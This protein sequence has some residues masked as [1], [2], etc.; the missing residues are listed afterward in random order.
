M[1]ELQTLKASIDQNPISRL[2]VITITI[3]AIINMLDGFDVLVMSFTAASISEAWG[4]PRPELGV[5][6]SAG[7]AGMALGSLFI[8]PYGDRIGRRAITL[9]CLGVISVGM[10]ASAYSQN[11][12]Q[13][14][15]LRFLTGLGIG[16]MIA[17]LNILVAEY[18]NARARSFAVSVLQSGYP[19]GAIIGGVI[20]IPLISNYGWQSAFLFGGFMSLLMIPITLW[21]LPESL[22]YLLTKQPR[23]ALRKVNKALLLMGREPLQALP[24]LTAEDNRKPS[25]ASL[26]GDASTRNTLALWT[27]YFMLMFS[28]Y[29]TFSWTPKLLTEA[30]L[31]ASQGIS[32]GLIIQVGGIIGSLILGVISGYFGLVRLTAIYLF[33]TFTMTVAFAT[34]LQAPLTLLMSVAFT[35]GFFLIGSMIGLYAI[36]PRLYPTFNRTTAMGWAIGVGRIG[37]II[38]PLLAGYLLEAGVEKSDS[39]IIFAVPLLIA[40]VAVMLFQLQEQASA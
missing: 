9:V 8:A 27:A 36:A 38:S 12:T 2:Q 5:L 13:L 33:A 32:G 20:S 30:G 15:A 28:M 37:A 14:A 17:S 39:F 21:I 40:G 11:V 29:F 18:S 10:I 3:C 35:M 7:L 34:F 6:L 4:I 31:S 25:V 1:S 19:A 23:D 26:F 16:S 24:E 22:D